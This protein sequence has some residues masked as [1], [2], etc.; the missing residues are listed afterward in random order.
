MVGIGIPNIVKAFDEHK[1]E[2]DRL[3][4]KLDS[5]VLLAW[6]EHLVSMIPK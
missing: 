6:F 4:R 5:F 3:S 1:G 2:C